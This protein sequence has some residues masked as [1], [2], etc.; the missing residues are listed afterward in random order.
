MNTGYRDARA[1]GI[2]FVLH[3]DLTGR[4]VEHGTISEHRWLTVTE[5][6]H[7]N[8]VAAGSPTGILI[9]KLCGVRKSYGSQ[10]VSSAADP[11]LRLL[12]G[13]KVYLPPGTVFDG[14]R[15][16]FGGVTF[17]GHGERE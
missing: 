4:V 1:M 16:E 14:T 7:Q 2:D 9:Q 12:Q 10:L 11:F 3:Q 6:Q 5:G 13:A 8:T 15:F 17:I